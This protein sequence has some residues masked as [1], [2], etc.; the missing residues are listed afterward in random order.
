MA[1]VCLG[2]YHFEVI[3]FAPII[4]KYTFVP[5]NGWIRMTYRK[6]FLRKF[7]SLSYEKF[8]ILH[9]V[10]IVILS[11]FFFTFRLPILVCFLCNLYILVP[12][13]ILHGQ[14]LRVK[15]KFNVFN[16]KKEYQRHHL[17]NRQSKKKTKQV[18]EVWEEPAPGQA[19]LEHH[20]FHWWVC[21]VSKL[22]ITL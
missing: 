19:R 11:T 13:K 22:V 5:C 7:F 10:Y 2:F 9:F 16:T 1:P 21:T 20:F 18:E 12:L 6:L 17:Q 15:V 4:W 8:R 14:Y 3:S